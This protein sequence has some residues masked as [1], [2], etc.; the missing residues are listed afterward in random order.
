M[1]QAV[2]SSFTN[3]TSAEGQT[4][5]LFTAKERQVQIGG[6]MNLH[7]DTGVCVFLAGQAEPVAMQLQHL[8]GQ[9]AISP[10]IS[11]SPSLLSLPPNSPL[12]HHPSIQFIPRYLPRSLCSRLKFTKCRRAVLHS[13]LSARNGYLQTDN[14]RLRSVIKAGRSA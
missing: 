2:S 13:S 10:F 7:M 14:A 4:W 11:T 6:L 12:T 9:C 5:P 3:N 1:T 8:V